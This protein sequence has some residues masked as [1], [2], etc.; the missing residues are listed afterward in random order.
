MV[1]ILEHERGRSA[2]K[3]AWLRKSYTLMLLA[4]VALAA[5]GTVGGFRATGIIPTRH[6]A[7]T[8]RPAQGAGAAAEAC[9]ACSVARASAPAAAHRV[10]REG[11]A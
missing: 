6:G 7:N 2:Q 10:R 1:E 8:Q 3:A 9:R 4:V 5:I 11:P